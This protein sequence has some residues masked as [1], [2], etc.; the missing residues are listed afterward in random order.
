MTACKS[1][2]SG[3]IFPADQ[4]NKFFRHFSAFKSSGVKLIH[5][6]PENDAGVIE[7]LP[8]HPL[9]LL[10][11]KETERRII[12]L[13]RSV[14]PAVTFLPD[15]DPHTVTQFKES[16]ALFVVRPPDEVTPHI[17]QMFQIKK[18]DLRR[19]SS[20]GNSTGVVA[21]EAFEEKFFTVEQKF[22]TFD[23]DRPD[24]ESFPESFSIVFYLQCMQKGGF[25]T[26]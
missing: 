18:H 6:S 17:F 13:I 7:I 22:F 8:D 16:A 15:K 24:P 23:C 26:P 21:V 14:L 3:R 9:R 25:R 5:K 4:C 12:K 10:F 20:P 2:Q 1:D 19:Y 11:H